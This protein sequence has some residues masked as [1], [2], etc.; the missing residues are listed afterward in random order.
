MVISPRRRSRRQVTRSRIKRG[1]HQSGAFLFYQEK[2]C[3]KVLV[4]V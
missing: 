2:I 1:K 3:G 4:T